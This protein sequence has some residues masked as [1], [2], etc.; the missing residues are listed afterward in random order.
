M[1]AP[2][3]ASAQDRLLAFEVAGSLYG[4]PIA[5]V[6]E[7]GE[8]EPL[9]GIP[10]LPAEVGGV[11][12]HHGDALPVLRRGALLGCDEASLGEPAHV[13]TVA[14]RASGGPRLGVPVDRIVGFV[15]GSAATAH[16]ED[17][18]AERRAVDGRV[19]FVLD[20]QRLVGRAKDQIEHALLR[21][22]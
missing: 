10:T 6:V 7:V 17:P 19:L 22:E 1:S 2:S 12:N 14:A 9:A 16:G 21:S 8:V 4:L 18:V 11:M 13:L 5:C 3:V 15:D 20:P